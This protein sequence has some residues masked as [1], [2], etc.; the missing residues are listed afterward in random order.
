MQGLH[1]DHVIAACRAMERKL[2]EANHALYEEARAKKVP[3][4]HEIFS[5]AYV[6]NRKVA[7]SQLM[8]FVHS[9]R[10]S[11][12]HQPG[13]G[14]EAALKKAWSEANTHSEFYF[15]L[16][17]TKFTEHAGWAAPFVAS[18]LERLKSL[19]YHLQLDA[20]DFCVYVRDVDDIVKARMIDALEKCLDKLGVLM[21][22]IIVEALKGLGA[23]EAEEENYVAVV[24]GEIDQALSE[25]SPQTDAEAWRLFSSQ[26]DHPYDST[27]WQEIQNLSDDRKKQLLLKA[28]RGAGTEYVSFVGILIRQL[29][30]FGDPEVAEAIEPWLNLPS[31]KSVMPQDAV[32]AF[33]AAHEAMGKLKVPLPAASRPVI[34]VDEAM[35]ACGELAYWACQL[36]NSELESSPH[37]LDAR[38]S[39]LARSASV[40]AG[41]L[42]ISTSRMLASDAAR[43]HL[44]RSYPDT[45]LAVCREALQHLHSQTSYQ[46]HG[47]RDDP[48]SIA[49]FSLQVVGQY[50]NADDLKSLR[51]LCDNQRLGPHALDAIKKI[52]GRVRY[53]HP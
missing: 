14:F 47:F 9:G 46:D 45:A 4:R 30:D 25:K 19:P 49:I 20:M 31:R 33:F 5:Q 38:R 21:N 17:V 15:L 29:S 2:I 36:A 34:D 3:L 24:Q 28:C 44:V 1:F 42:L 10:L 53:R 37:T 51:A 32:E 22:S 41:A 11:F 50:G 43:T 23:L 52:E 35:R 7:I 12:R 48:A 13:R 16:G 18:L 40:S 26:F 27:Y 6:F 8:Y 39:L